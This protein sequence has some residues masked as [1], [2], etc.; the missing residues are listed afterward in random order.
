MVLA[1]FLDSGLLEAFGNCARSENIVLFMA[2][3]AGEA[4]SH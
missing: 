2:H 1:E 3:A 4:P